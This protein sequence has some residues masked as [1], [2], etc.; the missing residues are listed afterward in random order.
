M[1]VLLSRARR[2]MLTAASRSGVVSTP[3]AIK[4]A[5]ASR[6]MSAQV[7][8]T[9]SSAPPMAL[10]SLSLIGGQAVTWIDPFPCS[11]HHTRFT[12]KNFSEITR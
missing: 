4:P 6:R 2:T 10:M 3:G 8:A 12:P 11:S 1:R 5:S 9:S 7:P